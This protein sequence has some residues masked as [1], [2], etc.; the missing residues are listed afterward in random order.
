M[1]TTQPGTGKMVGAQVRRVEDP[2]VLLGKSRYVNDIQMPGMLEIAF[3]RSLHAHARLQG[4]D[5][6]AALEYPG[7]NAVLTGEDVAS[8]IAPLRVEY[9]RTKAP[10][11]KPCDWP[12]LARGKVRFVGE[13]IAAVVACDRYVAEDAASLVEVDYEPMEAV[14]DVDRALTPTSPLVHEE[15]GDNVMQKMEAEIREVARAFQE[16]D[17]RNCGAL[18]HGASYG[19]ADGDAWLCGLFRFL[20]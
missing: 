10:T 11:Q 7:V 1:A 12:V 13:A 16:A 17:L 6:S 19:S 14:W 2:R 9:D 3:V 8:A 4:L 5:V 18:H 20:D 15:W